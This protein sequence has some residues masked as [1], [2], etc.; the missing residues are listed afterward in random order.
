MTAALKHA[1]IAALRTVPDG[2]K[3]RL[4]TIRA[5]VSRAL[6][7]DVS[8]VEIRRAFE[9]LY[10]KGMIDHKLN[11]S[12]SMRGSTPQASTRETEGPPSR[13]GAD[14]ACGAVPPSVA[15]IRKLI[16]LR[17]APSGMEAMAASWRRKAAGE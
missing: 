8:A 14:T 12:P 4:G 2:E 6:Y 5:H 13:S 11:L 17:H 3:P 1:V 16:D 15:P 7:R 10:F 9:A